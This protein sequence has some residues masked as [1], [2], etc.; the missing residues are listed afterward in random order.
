MS[1]VNNTNVKDHGPGDKPGKLPDHFEIVVIYNGQ[2]KP[3]KIAANELIKDVLAQAIALFGSLPNPHTLALYTEDGGE[4]KDE[5]Q[6]AE[7]A[8]L[9][10]GEKVL[11]RPSTVKAG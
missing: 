9:R 3:T 6:T 8:G 5:Q 10:P 1:Q 11:L 7:Q 2:T 4:L